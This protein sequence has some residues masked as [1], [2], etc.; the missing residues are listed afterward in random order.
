SG[1][2]HAASTAADGSTPTHKGLCSLIFAARRTAKAVIRAF[3]PRNR[4]TG[5]RVHG[6]S[7]RVYRVLSAHRRSGSES[8]RGSR[9]RRRE[10]GDGPC[11]RK[12]TGAYL[13]TPTRR[14]DAAASASTAIEL[15][16]IEAAKLGAPARSVCRLI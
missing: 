2:L 13:W 11:V 8:F 7:A 6:K 4:A 1:S 12:F 3:I 15:R 16:L 9:A 5:S 14:T 10:H